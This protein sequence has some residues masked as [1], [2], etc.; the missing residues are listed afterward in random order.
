MTLLSFWIATQWVAQAL[1]YQPRLG[2][3]WFAIGHWR[4]YRPWEY[5]RWQWG[6]SAYAPEVFRGGF[7]ICAQ[8]PL[9]AVVAML[10]F[11]VWRSRKVRVAIYARLGSLGARR[12]VPNRR[13]ARTAPAW[14]SVCYP[15]DNFSPTTG[16]ARRLYCTDPF[17]QGRRPGHSDLLTWPGSVLVHDMKGENWQHSAGYRARILQ[18]HLFQPDRTYP[19][20][21]FQPPDGSAE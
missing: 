13:P 8:G 20:G 17:G 12:R 18:R 16:Q 10:A 6:Y 2:A 11:A 9:L 3:H 14:C 21:T 19:F 1:A 5:W 7:V 15:T 4:I